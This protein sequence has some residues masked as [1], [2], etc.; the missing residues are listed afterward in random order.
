MSGSI[1]NTA[2]WK[3]LRLAHLALYPLCRDCAERGMTVLANT[4][5]HVVP[6][7]AG[8]SAYPGHDGLSSLCGPCHSRKTARGVEAGAVRTTRKAGVRKGCD[9]AGNPIDPTHPWREGKSL[10]AD[11]LNTA[12]HLNTQLVT[13]ADYFG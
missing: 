5:D 1:Y 12:I 13:F 4:V 3:Q 7:S 9:A 8:G 10:G 11:R 2:R 6:V